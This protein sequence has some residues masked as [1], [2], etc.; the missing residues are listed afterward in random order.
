MGIDLIFGG[1]GRE[2]KTRFS[3]VEWDTFA[4]LE[5]F[6]PDA[7]A[8]VVGG[9]S[10]KLGE[11][12]ILSV[13]DTLSGID[14]I[15]DFLKRR[16][17]PLPDTFMFKREYLMLRGSRFPSDEDFVTGVMSGLELP[18]DPDHSYSIQVGLDE[19]HLTKIAIGP[20]GRGRFVDRRDLRE[21]EMIETITCGQIQVRKRSDHAGIR[22]ELA[23]VRKFLE[24]LAGPE[25]T[26][27]ISG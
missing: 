22:E 2:F 26:R 5:A 19:C 7:V 8:A 9:P 27:T 6:L 18:G 4:R 11:D 3:L 15:D 23:R 21:E 20:D 25:V 10:T 24:S 17:S 1:D 16:P 14:Q 12:E 13:V